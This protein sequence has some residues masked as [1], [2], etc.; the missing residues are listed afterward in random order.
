MIQ[1]W[2]G[3][4]FTFPTNSPYFSARAILSRVATAEYGMGIVDTRKLGK[5]VE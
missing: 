2:P 3:R 1:L 4:T 5:E